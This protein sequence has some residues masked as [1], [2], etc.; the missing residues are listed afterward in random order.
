M[1][2]TTLEQLRRVEPSWPEPLRF[3]DRFLE[4]LRVTMDQIVEMENNYAGLAEF[5]AAGNRTTVR[6]GDWFKMIRWTLGMHRGAAVTPAAQQE[7]INAHAAGRRSDAALQQAVY[8]GTILA[9]FGTLSEPG[10]EACHDGHT[11]LMDYAMTW[12]VENSKQRD[13]VTWDTL[14][15]LFTDME[16]KAANASNA[17]EGVA[18]IRAMLQWM[19]VEPVW[20]THDQWTM[21]AVLWRFDHAATYSAARWD[22]MTDRHKQ[23]RQALKANL[24]IGDV[25]FSLGHG[26]AYDRRWYA[27]KQVVIRDSY[28]E[29]QGP[30]MTFT[31]PGLLSSHRSI[32]DVVEEVPTQ[33]KFLGLDDHVLAEEARGDSTEAKVRKLSMDGHEITQ[34][35][36][37]TMYGGVILRSLSTDEKEQINAA[38]GDLSRVT[39]GA[40][41]EITNEMANGG[42]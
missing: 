34:P 2:E 20:A 38:V 6:Q 11:K 35:S 19:A 29:Q 12:F 7:I 10:G 36:G 41:S 32:H 21:A 24:N 17:S 37:F 40:L 8:P 31:G 9:H 15:R 25:V 27:P 23:R 30:W 22:G 5:V 14:H 16:A 33:L 3:A 13:P 4:P 28:F 26:S 39:A 1:A 42:E 18:W